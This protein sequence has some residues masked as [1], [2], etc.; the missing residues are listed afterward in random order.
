LYTPARGESDI[1][2]KQLNASVHHSDNYVTNYKNASR[3]QHVTYLNW[4][5][6]KDTP[7]DKG[8]AL[9]IPGDISE[10]A[11]KKGVGVPWEEVMVS[12]NGIILLLS[13]ISGATVAL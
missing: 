13:V 1:N 5:Q 6:T 7:E 12:T 8:I 9:K 2:L 10:S 3:M 11:K 4:I